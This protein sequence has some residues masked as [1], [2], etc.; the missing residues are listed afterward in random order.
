[1]FKEASRYAELGWKVFPAH[2]ITKKGCSCGKNCGRDAGKHPAGYF[3]K[4]LG[5]QIKTYEIVP[6]GLNDATDNLVKIKEWWDIAPFNIGIR[7]GAESSIFVLDP[8][9]EIGLQSLAELETVNGFLP[10]TVTAITGGGGRHLFF[11]HPG[12]YVKSNS[13]YWES[14]GFPKIDVKGDGGYVI[15]APS[16]HRSGKKYQWIPGQAPGEIEI[17]D[18]PEWLL[19]LIQEAGKADG[20]KKVMNNDELDEALDEL[21]NLGYDG[22]LRVMGKLISMK[23]TDGMIHDIWLARLGDKYDEDLTQSKINSLRAKEVANDLKEKGEIEIADLENMKM[24]AITYLLEPYIPNRN[25]TVVHAGTATAK[26]LLIIKIA[27]RMS[28]GGGEIPNVGK[29]KGGKVL[30]INTEDTLEDAF[31]PRLNAIDHDKNN[32]HTIDGITQDFLYNNPKIEEMVNK[33]GYSLIVI[34]ILKDLVDGEFDI[35][36]SRHIRQAVNYYK[37]LAAKYN[38]GVILIHHNNKSKSDSGAGRV[39][40]SGDWYTAARSV[41]EL[42]KD[43]NTGVINVLHHKSNHGKEGA[44][45]GFTISVKDLGKDDEGNPIKPPYIEKF[46]AATKDKEQVDAEFAGK[47]ETKEEQAIKF[48]F[49]CLTANKRVDGQELKQFVIS[50]GITEATFRRA[51]TAMKKSGWID[52]ERDGMKVFWFKI[53]EEPLS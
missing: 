8:D 4:D 40:G 28:A 51:Q 5:D 19:K 31:L 21:P 34:D 10:E 18:A 45:F 7:T 9:G 11:K 53:E 49:E 41:L 33:N 14:I 20:K 16:K 6:N 47:E 30:Y 32:F 1:M 37:D 50:K 13:Q 22:M 25:V 48:I 27:G 15:T 17:A 23:L 52:S 26:S 46:C 43:K 24:K 12:F 42:Q 44:A 36:A 29:V 39:Q 35:N 38:L 3:T 2:T